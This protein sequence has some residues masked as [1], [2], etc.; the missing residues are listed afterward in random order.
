MKRRIVRLFA[1]ATLVSVLA[2]S[3]A[4]PAKCAN[5]VNPTPCKNDGTMIGMDIGN[6]MPKQHKV[7]AGIVSVQASYYCDHYSYCDNMYY[8]GCNQYLATGTSAGGC[9]LPYSKISTAGPAARTI[10]ANAATSMGLVPGGAVGIEI[11]KCTCW[12]GYT[13]CSGRL[14]IPM[15]YEIRVPISGYTPVMLA[16]L[17]NGAVLKLSDAEFDR[18]TAG[19]WCVDGT[20][21]YYLHTVYPDAVYMMAYLPK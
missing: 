14:T 13:P 8:C 15:N 12:S 20:Q 7:G 16:L 11:G 17:S 18:S 3:F 19:M 4:V 2:V 1:A 6:E 9:E 21:M 10:L 5:Y